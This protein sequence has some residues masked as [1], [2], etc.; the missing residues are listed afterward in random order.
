MQKRR[1]LDVEKPGFL[2]QQKK[3]NRKRES[4]AT[5]FNHINNWIEGEG[6]DQNPW[7]ICFACVCALRLPTG[8]STIQLVVVAMIV[9][10]TNRIQDP[11][12]RGADEVPS[13]SSSSSSVLFVM[14]LL[15]LP[16]PMAPPNA[17][18]R[19]STGVAVGQRKLTLVV[20]EISVSQTNKLYRD[21][22]VKQKKATRNKIVFLSTHTLLFIRFCLFVRS[23]LSPH[24]S[25]LDWE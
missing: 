20:L 8:H 19:L 15:L 13:S 12:A 4:E 1:V 23:S 3:K 10:K 2:N 14:L 9:V 6:H 21:M 22:K 11:T 17:S 16:I 25:Y 18:Q 24:N 7:H 5:I